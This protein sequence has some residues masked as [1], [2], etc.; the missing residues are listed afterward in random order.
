MSAT[1]ASTAP[2]HVW[3]LR[4]AAAATGL[5]IAACFLWFGLFP[6]AWVAFAPLLWALRHDLDRREVSRLGLIAG[7]CTN[8][9][10]FYWLVYTI[11]VF[12]G[13]PYPLAAAFYVGLSLYASVQFVLF[14]HI[15]RRCGRGPLALAAPV[16]WV[17]LEFLYPNLFPWRMAHSQFHAP[18]LIQVG[19]L[20]GPFA[21]SFVLVWSAAGCVDAL[22]TPRRWAATAGAAVTAAAII[23]YGVWRLPQI[24]AAIA[25]APTFRVGLVQGNISIEEKGDRTYFD[26]NLDRYADL[27]E[28]IQDDVDLLIWPE[29]VSQHWTPAD[30]YVLEE[31]LHP[32]PNARVPLFFGGLAYRITGPQQADEFN[33][34]F[35]VGA[36]G[37]VLDRYDK[38]ILMPFGEFLPGD[39]WFPWIKKLS[40]ATASFKA[41]QDVKVFT[42]GDVRIGALICYEDIVDDMPRATTNAGAE[43]LATILNDAWYGYSP[44][45]HQHQALALW[46]T[47]ENRRYL[48]RGSN[49]GVTSIIDAAGRVLDEG[50]LF[51]E[52]VIVGDVARLRIPTVYGRIGNAFAWTITT[53][54]G[55]W[56]LASA[57]SKRRPT[58]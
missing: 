15:M 25:A 20:T 31:K 54:A 10:A 18:V 30:A 32:F 2:A 41:G 19:D 27:S 52:E 35:L 28:P 39:Q 14:A 29:T 3:R 21:L 47:I 55:L 4:A 9:P 34:A 44:A 5:T 17:T 6:L 37:R 43:V 11:N 42:L 33:S 50:G 48:L 57:W 24:D 8:I 51:T 56:L 7:L 49:T 12:G 58:H 23:A 38:R 1:N 40:P 45:A 26:V 46:R 13:F 53:I 16:A 22:T 36:D